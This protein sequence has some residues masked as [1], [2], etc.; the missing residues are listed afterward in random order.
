MCQIIH[1][2]S[3]TNLGI[4]SFSHNLEADIFYKY[5]GLKMGSA[6]QHSSELNIKN[7]SQETYKSGKQPVLTAAHPKIKLLIFF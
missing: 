3:P 7:R 6:W 5:H 2:T 4:L 1:P